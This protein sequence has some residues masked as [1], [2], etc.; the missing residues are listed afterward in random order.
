[1]RENLSFV[2]RL[3]KDERRETKDKN[4]ITCMNVVSDALPQ[5]QVPP[6]SG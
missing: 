3:A 5:T 6:Y 4:H 1:M 2:L